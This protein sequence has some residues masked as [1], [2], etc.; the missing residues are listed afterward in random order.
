MINSA[1]ILSVS[2]KDYIIGL[3]WKILA[4][5]DSA[6]I[7]DTEQVLAALAAVYLREDKKIVS[8]GYITEKNISPEEEVSDYLK[9]PSLAAAIIADGHTD[10]VLIE[11][12][13]E[14]NAYLFAVKDGQVVAGTDSIK[15]AE[16]AKGEALELSDSLALQ[17]IEGGLD[18]FLESEPTKALRPVKLRTGS[19]SGE[20]V[21]AAIAIA[22]IVASGYFG[23]GMLFPTADTNTVDIGARTSDAWR[24]FNTQ[25]ERD[26]AIVNSLELYGNVL[27]SV[28]EL[29]I[30]LLSWEFEGMRCA[31][32]TNICV[33]AYLNTKNDSVSFFRE[34]MPSQYAVSTAIDGS[35]AQVTI[36]V[37]FLR[38]G[39]ESAI[40]EANEFTPVFSDYVQTVKRLNE[41]TMTVSK[42]TEALQNEAVTT[43]LPQGTSYN[44]GGFE[45]TSDLNNWELLASLSAIPGVFV[46]T[47]VMGKSELKMEGH[48]VFK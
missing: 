45:I 26:T 15:D 11:Q 9:V 39:G 36:N 7:K 41:T 35:N 23:W 18:T 40:P 6:Q 46:T 44:K 21:K 48:Y 43:F 24:Q 3:D 32:E 25:L 30:S 16:L 37:P 12:I 31:A 27:A 38:S 42:P 4:D 8:A 14:S 22:V 47:I 28:D 29:P 20:A 19:A 10:I 33:A 34:S 5:A 13:D 17:L 2:G 1:A